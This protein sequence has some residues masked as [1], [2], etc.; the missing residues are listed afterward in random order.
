MGAGALVNKNCKD[1]GLYVGVPAV[2]IGWVNILGQKLKLPLSGIN[3]I[4]CENSNLTYLL[5][6]SN[7]EIMND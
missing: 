1:F 6:G 5:K 7:L 4:N 3:Q 2:Q